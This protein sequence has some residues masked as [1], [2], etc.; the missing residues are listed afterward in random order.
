[1]NRLTSKAAWTAVAALVGFLLGNYGLYA[2]IGLTDA[3]YKT[4]VDL[5]F[6]AL[7]AFGIFNNPTDK[8]NF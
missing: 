2:K 6:V 1:M 8:E 5:I 4:L 7:A 3:T